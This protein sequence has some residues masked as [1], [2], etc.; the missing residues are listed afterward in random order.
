MA[1]FP[2]RGTAPPVVICSYLSP[3]ALGVEVVGFAQA[4]TASGALTANIVY[5]VPFRLAAP[6]TAA[7]MFIQNGTSLGANFDLGIYTQD[8]KQIVTTGVTAQVGTSVLQIVDMTDTLLL[9]GRYYMAL[10]TNTTAQVARMAVAL[11]ILQSMGELQESSATLPATATFAKATA[12]H[13]P[14]IGI[15]GSTTV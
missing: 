10:V 5:Y 12:T 9:P 2:V 8:G 3:E 4:Y 14:L 7:Q 13:L 6:Y 15:T 11:V 1:D